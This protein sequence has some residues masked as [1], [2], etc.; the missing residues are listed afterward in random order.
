VELCRATALGRACTF[1]HCKRSHDGAAFL[2]AREPDLPGQC[3]SFAQ[4]GVCA[5]GLACR[6]V[7]SHLDAA[8][9]AL[10]VDEARQAANPPPT[11]TSALTIDQQRAIERR[12]AKT[13]RA[14][15]F[16]TVRDSPDADLAAR[17]RAGE[18]RPVDFRQKLVLAPLTTVGHAAFR[19]ICKSFGA[20]ITVSEMALAH[21]LVQG[22]GAEWALLRRHSSEDVFGIQLASGAAQAMAQAIELVRDF[23]DVSADYIS[24]NAGC[25][26]DML[27]NHGGGAQLSCN[28]NKLRNMLRGMA[29]IADV[30]VELKIRTGRTESEPLA[31][32]FIGELHQWGVA[33]VTL[34]GRSRRSRYTE[35]AQRDYMLRCAAASTVPFIANGDIYSFE[36]AVELWSADGGHVAGLMIGRG[37]L[38]KP[39]LFQEIKERRHIDIAASERLEIVRQFSQNALDLFGSDAR[40]VANARR[41]LCEWL[42]FA[43]RYVPVGILERMPSHLHEKPAPWR[44]RNELETLLGSPV[45]ADWVKISNMF[46]G[47]APSDFQFEPKHQSQAYAVEGAASDGVQG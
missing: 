5:Y 9:S 14:D 7:G 17:K 2:A 46:L 45:V 31:H 6:F 21:E 47:E 30:P 8:T 13:P 40:G 22:K 38:I 19:R 41:Y 15:A 43:H 18:V 36:D 28:P 23:A 39:W 34:H 27:C 11:R 1:A 29:T 10:V 25:P 35:P 16:W 37:A 32:T 3:P 12:Q 42:S 44:G 33:A 26:L 4:H 24:L 20:D